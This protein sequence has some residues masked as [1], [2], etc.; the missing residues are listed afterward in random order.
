MD[1]SLRPKSYERS[2]ERV[3][4]GSGRPRGTTVD[5][6]ALGLPLAQ[7][8]RRSRESEASRLGA[9]TMVSARAWQAG[10]QSSF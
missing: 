10:K 6:T 1:S 8:E 4:P 5:P 9:D 3:D 7:A 2:E